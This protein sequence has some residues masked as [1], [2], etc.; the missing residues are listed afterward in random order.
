[1]KFVNLALSLSV[2]S[3]ASV[4]FGE[5]D[6]SSKQTTAEMVQCLSAN[7]QEADQTLNHLWPAYKAHFA[8]IDE[9]NKSST[10][11]APQEKA[12]SLAVK[13]QKA[14]IKIRDNDCL[15]AA[16]AFKGGTLAPVV[17]LSCLVEKTKERSNYLSDTV[18]PNSDSITSASV[19]LDEIIAELPECQDIVST[20][21]QRICYAAAHKKADAELN[22][23]Y[24]IARSAIKRQPNS[25]ETLKLLTESQ[26]SWISLRDA[27][28]EASAQE[29]WG[30]SLYFSV[31]S[32]CL[33]YV[34]LERSFEIRGTFPNK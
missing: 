15:A 3:V 9:A 8:A 29:N 5:E 6:C 4:A 14:W 30:G 24:Q 22:E 17:Q 25:A 1:M 28:C 2:L 21:G 11:P 10:L 26:K 18:N 32:G 7:Y 27:Q 34:S 33:S 16:A 20:H 12:L 23:W 13:A 31:K 19:R